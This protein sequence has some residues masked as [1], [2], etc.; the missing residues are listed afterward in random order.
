MQDAMPGRGMTDTPDL[1]VFQRQLDGSA[2]A[3]AERECSCF[4]RAKA[5]FLLTVL[6]T[7][8][9]ELC[10]FA[11]APPV[12]KPLDHGGDLLMLRYYLFFANQLR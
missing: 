1:F 3:W 10:F 8:D 4:Y 6:A 7:T 5:D 11:A 2:A 9:K 12:E